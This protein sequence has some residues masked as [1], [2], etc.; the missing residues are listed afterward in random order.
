MNAAVDE[1]ISLEFLIY[2]AS[3]PLPAS[4]QAIKQANLYIP[5]HQQKTPRHSHRVLL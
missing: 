5:D 4:Q 1:A 3:R 2:A